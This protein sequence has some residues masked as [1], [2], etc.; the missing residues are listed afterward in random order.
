MVKILE[1]HRTSVKLF[2][3]WSLICLVAFPIVEARVRHY[4]WDVKYEYKSPDCFQKLVMT[5]NGGT[6]GPTILAQQGDTIVVELKNSLLTDNI[7]IHWH[8]IRQ[9]S[10]PLR[11]AAFCICWLNCCSFHYRLNFSHS[12]SNMVSETCCR[13]SRI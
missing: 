13:R 2:V 9:V 4:R 5:I 1:L 12:L 11:H 7:A 3:L 10:V 6:P 8:G